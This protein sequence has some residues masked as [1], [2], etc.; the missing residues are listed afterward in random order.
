MATK[1][2]AEL[3]A[4]LREVKSQLEIKTKEEKNDDCANE[5]HNLYKS[6]VKVGF[7]EDQAW[8]LTSQLVI[9]STRPKTSIF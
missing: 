7:T 6:F 9:N 2:K 4:E 5:I 8:I 1:T 3:E